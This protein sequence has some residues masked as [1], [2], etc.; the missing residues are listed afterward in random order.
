M[1]NDTDSQQSRR[2]R[3]KPLT[4]G[5]IVADRVEILQPLSIGDYCQV[6]LGKD[7]ELPGKTIAIKILSPIAATGDTLIRAR[8]Q[9]EIK[10][11][12]RV[13]HQNV[14]RTYDYL[15][16]EFITAYTMEYFPGGDLAT[17]LGSKGQLPL[18][19][20]LD[21]FVQLCDGLQAIHSAGIVH[22]DIKPENILIADNGVVKISDFGIARMGTTLGKG[23]SILGTITYLSPEYLRDGALDQRSDIYSAGIVAFELLTGKVPVDGDSVVE[24][25]QKQ[26]HGRHPAVHELNPFC[27]IPV[28]RIISR[29][30]QADPDKRYQSG[31]ELMQ[32]LQQAC[33][34]IGVSPSSAQHPVVTEEHLQR[35]GSSGRNPVVLEEPQEPLLAR[36]PTPVKA[37]LFVLFAVVFYVV[38]SLIFAN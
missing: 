38:L 15:V 28:S 4:P 25:M 27:P 36:I 37:L 7:R 20:A 21:I 2:F 14:V 12:H 26:V 13:R 3:V 10:A 33:R 18:S 35:S 6:Y 5:T 29:A 23:R 16:N 8:F 34:A 30:L 9:N 22:R 31:G 19:Q 1:N 24:I 11:S 17:L 32:D